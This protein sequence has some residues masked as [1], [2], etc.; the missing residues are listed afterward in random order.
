MKDYYVWFDNDEQDILLST[1]FPDAQSI[2]R[3]D[4]L[5]DDILMAV[6]Y[7]I[8]YDVTNDHAARLFELNV[9]RV[10][11]AFNLAYCHPLIR[12][13]VI[14]LCIENNKVGL[15]RF[16]KHKVTDIIPVLD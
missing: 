3:A 7:R 15:L 6:E 11:Q 1:I 14:E 10:Q 5:L 8:V 4:K 13:K 16:H 12:R 2:S 9:S